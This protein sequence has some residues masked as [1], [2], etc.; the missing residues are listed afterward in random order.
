MDQLKSYDVQ[1]RGQAYHF[2]FRYTYS[3][4]GYKAHIESMP[5]YGRRSTSLSATHRLPDGDGY[6]ICWSGKIRTEAEM[7]AI[8]ALWANA[9]VMYIVLGGGSINPHVAALQR[10][11]MP[12]QDNVKTY[13]VNFAGRTYD[14]TFRYEHDS[15]NGYRAFI[16]SMPGYGAR[17]SALTATHRLKEGNRHYVCWSEK[18]WSEEALDA[19]VSL[20]CRASVMYIVLGGESLDEHA[21]KLFRA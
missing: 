19:V 2:V 11:E 20:W 18:I 4:E 6:K 9:T 1:F 21:A 3:A 14:F 16:E 8:A 10:G 17:S 12:N 7:D 5:G 15:T 13:S